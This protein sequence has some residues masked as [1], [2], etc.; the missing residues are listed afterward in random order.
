MCIGFVY[1]KI[2]E[3]YSVFKRMK[4]ACLWC[5]DF[6]SVIFLGMRMIVKFLI[7]LFK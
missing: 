3:V 4:E 5:T 1:L 6:L 2:G 7:Y